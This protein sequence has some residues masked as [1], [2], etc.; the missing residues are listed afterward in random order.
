M[1]SGPG[2]GFHAAPARRNRRRAA[3]AAVLVLSLA[4]LAVA[5]AGLVAQALPR[6][7][8][9]AQQRQI[10]AWE[11]AKRWRSLPEG[12]IF[13]ATV[14]Y[15]LPGY[16]LDGGR[17]LAL[18]ARRL[19]VSSAVRCDRGAAP[20]A[21]RILD[22]SGC[23]ALLRATYADSTGSIVATVGV[24]VLPGDAAARAA[25]QQLASAG[26][27]NLPGSVR[28][29]PVP[30]TLAA[31]FYDGQRQLSWNTRTGPYVVLATVGYA[32][33]RPRV[34]IAADSYQLAE[35]TNLDQGL[36]Q[37]VS[38]V[39]GRTPATPTCPGAPGC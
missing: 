29:A 30:G 33:G 15:H 31:H 38:G 10:M 19:G 18:R 35:M 27:R 8:S 36:A 24:A 16:A 21:G 4:G 17:S 37:A 1:Q 9:A 7:F 14:T 23:R 3:L 39:L 34:H 11:I 20:A 26:P 6:Q 5:A 22:R 12:T 13:P 2:D 25:Q 32:D 28:T